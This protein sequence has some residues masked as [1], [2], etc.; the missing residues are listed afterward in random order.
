MTM[1]GAV[2]SAL[3]TTLLVTLAYE[4]PVAVALEP[5]PGIRPG[6]VR[7]RRSLSQGRSWRWTSAQSSV[8]FG[9]AGQVF[10]GDA[11]LKLDLGLPR[12]AATTPRRLILAIDGQHLG[13]F[14]VPAGFSHHEFPLPRERL[15]SGDWVLSLST[16]GADLVPDDPRGIALARIELVQSKSP[17]V[18][19][20]RTLLLAILGLLAFSLSL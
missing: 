15:S 18:P 16:L 4:R 13:A 6:G 7:A 5:G 17:V 3:L 1:R 10:A 12:W 9:L 11:V 14:D 20:L 8:R 2:G 19:A